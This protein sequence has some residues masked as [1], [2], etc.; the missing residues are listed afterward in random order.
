M[1]RLAHLWMGFILI[2]AIITAYYPIRS[3]TI[4]AQDG[5][6]EIS[7]PEPTRVE[8][9]ASDGLVLVGDFYAGNSE[10][11]EQAPP[12]SYSI[13]SVAIV[14]HGNLF[15]LCLLEIMGLL[16]SILICEDMAKQAA[17]KNGL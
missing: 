11:G 1:R 17:P 4:H 15:Y 9:E 2:T 10:D 6:D 5:E 12:Y 16:F 14:V 8:I 3:A 7:L 13:C